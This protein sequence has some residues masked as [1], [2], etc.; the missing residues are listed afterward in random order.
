MLLALGLLAGLAFWW[1][2]KTGDGFGRRLGR[3]V[4][5]GVR[6][7]IG[8][9]PAQTIAG[10]LALAAAGV[11]LLRGNLVLAG[12]LGLGGIWMLEGP[13][14]IGRR[15]RRLFPSG[16]AARPEAGRRYRTGVIEMAMR[17]DGSVSEG[18]VIA[19]PGAGT[20]LD[21]LPPDAVVELLRACRERDPEGA[22]L[23]EA[24]LDRRASGWR[25][26][27]QRDH[28]PRA[29]RAPDPGAMT[30]EDAHQI[31]GLQRGASPGEIRTAHRS[32][33]KRAH[34]DQGGNAERAARLNAARDR[35]LSRH[36]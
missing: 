17:P 1:L 14:G 29:G 7:A 32:L 24:Y 26:H 18:W 6:T 20:R 28:D 31:L 11:L 23:L 15:I 10:S 8:P 22:A 34:P 5:Q 35:L 30:Q 36:R 12:L 21:D 2:S 27:A 16:P 33:M 9:I 19:G 25:V 3:A 4:G 13:D